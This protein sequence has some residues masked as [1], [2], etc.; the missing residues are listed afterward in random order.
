MGVKV[1]EWK[2]AWWLFIDHSGR[3][4]AKRVGPGPSGKKAAELAGTK[5]RARLVEGD[6]SVLESER[7]AVPTFKEYAERWLQGIQGRVRPSTLE[8]YQ[9]RVRQMEAHLGELP[10]TRITREVVRTL[11]GALAEVRENGKRLSRATLK[12]TLNTL[13]SILGTAEEDGLIPTN[14]ARRIG[15]K[16]LP[17]Q[18]VVEAEVFT[19]QELAAILAVAERDYPAYYPLLFTLARTGMRLGEALGLEWADVDFERRVFLVRRASRRGHVT[20][21]KSHQ[22]RRVDM[23]AQLARVLQD[24]KSLQEAEA[25]LRGRPDPERVF[26]NRYGRLVNEMSLRHVWRSILRRAEVRY[27]KIHCLR[28]TF[29]SMLIEAGVPLPYIQR[30]LG[31]HS[32]AFT[33]KVYG[34]L[35]PRRERREVDLLDD[36]PDATPAQPTNP[37]FDDAAISQA[38]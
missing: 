34:H 28:H 32:P 17:P 8:E 23:S 19:R 13:A 36:Q 30:Q 12:E 31:H 1:K 37:S 27:R 21:P 33:L 22:A 18:D 14:P 26:V 4:K 25:V 7:P 24:W 20:T 6:L 15:K 5:I 16:V 3:R 29:A 2:G 35:I 9:R 11:F 10:L 38:N